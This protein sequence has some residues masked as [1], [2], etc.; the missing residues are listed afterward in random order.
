MTNNEKSMVGVVVCFS[1]VMLIGSALVG[2]PAPKDG[3]GWVAKAAGI[4]VMAFCGGLLAYLFYK[5][6]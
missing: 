1:V 4:G 6:L 3:Y 2:M 5:K